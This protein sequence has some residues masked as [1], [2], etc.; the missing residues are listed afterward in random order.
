MPKGELAIFDEGY[1]EG[2]IDYQSFTKSIK[3]SNINKEASF[4]IDITSKPTKFYLIIQAK[5]EKTYLPRWRLW[6]DNF[7]LTK[8]FK[9]NL[10]TE[11]N[12][13]QVISTIVYDITP[14]TK[15]GKHQ[16]AVYHPSIQTLELLNLSLISFYKIEGFSTKYRLSAGSLIL[17]R[18]DSVSFQLMKKSYFVI[19]NESKEGMV[20]IS[21]TDGKTIYTVLPSSDSDEIEIE[22]N[23]VVTTT[24]QS[25]NEKDYGVIL[26]S[27]NLLE[28]APK[29]NFSVDSKVN[30]NIIYLYLK[31]ESEI[32][33]DKLIINVMINGVPAHFKT[34][35]NIE[36][37]SAIDL[38]LPISIPQNKKAQVINIRVV[39]I[40]GGYRKII[41]K[42]ISL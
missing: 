4:S 41:D 40:K 28:K 33:L 11:V 24:L 13:I 3:L 1:F 16:I 15:E 20:K 8:E 18:N 30:N 34:F 21:D 29:I 6:F 7:S 5:R 26:A 9:P 22:N 36:I 32:S 19:R 12:D 2:S 38:K 31:S 27:Y 10:E 42:Q 23:D 37:D 35:T 39:G 14:I 17:N 25:N